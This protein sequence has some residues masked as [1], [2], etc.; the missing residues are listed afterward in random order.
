PHLTKQTVC[1]VMPEFGSSLQRVSEEVAAHGV[2]WVGEAKAV[3]VLL[4]LLLAVRHLQAHCVAHCDIKPDNVLLDAGTWHAVLSDFGMARKLVS[5]KGKPT[6]V[7][8][9]TQLSGGNLLT[10]APEVKRLMRMDAADLVDEEVTLVEA[11]SKAEEFACAA[12]LLL[13]LLGDN[14]KVFGDT[15]EAGWR[16][17]ALPGDKYSA[18]F[19]AVLRQLL[20]AEPA[21]RLDAASGV[22]MLGVLLWRRDAVPA[23]G[24]AWGGVGRVG[25]HDGVDAVLRLQWLQV[26]Q[27]ARG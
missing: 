19:R 9:P 24:A 5:K 25:E 13:T 27:E 2:G 15:G 23:A 6:P 8:S 7:G 17:P 12:T 10:R 22:L 3:K 20:A 21:Q 1:V 4:Q 14:G 11:F 16:A 26:V 18:G